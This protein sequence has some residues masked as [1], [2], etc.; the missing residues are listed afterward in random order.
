MRLCLATVLCFAL[1]GCHRDPVPV[2]CPPPPQIEEPEYRTDKLSQ[3]STLEEVVV[4]L[5]LDLKEARATLKRALVILD[6]YRKPDQ[7][8][9]KEK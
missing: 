4:A 1:V 7:K 9:E 3:E 6:S 8:K 5:T 2:P